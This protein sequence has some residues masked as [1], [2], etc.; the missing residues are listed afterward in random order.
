VCH[1]HFGRGN[2]SDAL[3][4]GSQSRGTQHEITTIALGVVENTCG[5]R[6]CARGS[7]FARRPP[8][9]KGTRLERNAFTLIELLVVISI[10]ALLI[11]I[12]L[13]A[14]GKAREESWKIKCMT[15]LRGLGT[16]MQLYFNDSDGVLPWVDP[17]AGA[18]ENEN[19]TDLF[20]VFAAYIDATPPRREI[21]GDET[22]PWIVQDP[23]SC[24]ADKI[25]LDDDNNDS[26]TAQETYGTSY[27]APWSEIY[28]ALEL[29]GAIDTGN[30]DERIAAA[31]RWKGQRAVSRAYDH[32]ATRGE[33]L[34]VMLDFVEVHPAKSGKN[35]LFWD[36]SVDIYPGDPPTEFVE[37]FIALTLKLCNFGG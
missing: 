27:A 9:R 21:R 29:F 19:S 7:F 6:A 22:S 14:L 17:I 32:Y 24:P 37:D 11:G 15:N 16:S 13:P 34:A 2:A 26:R 33:K 35:A 5:S 23:Y 8:R 31:E 36:S 28:V 18:D 4:H 20:E 1:G 12:L 10:I 25:A 3:P 30:S